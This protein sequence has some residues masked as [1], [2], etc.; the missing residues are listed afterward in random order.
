MAVNNLNNNVAYGLNN[1]L[2]SLSPLPIIAKR[3]PTANDVAEYGAMWIYN[4]NV[5]IFTSSATWTLVS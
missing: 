4:D 2:Q 3:A 1:G 5:W